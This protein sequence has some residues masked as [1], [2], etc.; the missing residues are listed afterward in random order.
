MN[1][2]VIFTVGLGVMGVVL[3]SA[4][5]ALIASDHPDEPD[6]PAAPN[7]NK[8]EIGRWIDLTTTEVDTTLTKCKSHFS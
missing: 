8:I 4:F 7:S 3:A 5:V 1:D 2:V 6:P